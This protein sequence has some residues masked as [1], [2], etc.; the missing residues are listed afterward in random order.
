MNSTYRHIY[1]LVILAYTTI[2][3]NSNF[4]QYFFSLLLLWPEQIKRD[5]WLPT[6]YPVGKLFVG[7][8]CVSKN[9]ANLWC[10]VRCACAYINVIHL[11]LE[12][13]LFCTASLTNSMGT[14]RFTC[15]WVHSEVQ[16]LQAD[17]STVCRFLLRT[18][19]CNAK[20]VFATEEASVCRSVCLPHCCIVSKRRNLGSWNLHHMIA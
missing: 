8:M 18:T 14:V 20:R 11:P 17:K 15:I 2:D 3:N 10:T 4:V 7:K 19:A 13:S 12:L 1:L 16:F 6:F 5:H 9:C